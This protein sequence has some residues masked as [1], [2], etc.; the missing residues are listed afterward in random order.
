[1]E[2]ESNLTNKS[3]KEISAKIVDSLKTVLFENKNG[4]FFKIYTHNKIFI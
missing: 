4:K 3:N 1:M 2:E